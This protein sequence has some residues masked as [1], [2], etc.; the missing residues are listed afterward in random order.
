V[1]A[2]HS[3]VGVSVGHVLH[4]VEHVVSSSSPSLG[5][6]DDKHVFRLEKDPQ[7]DQYYFKSGLHAV[8]FK[9]N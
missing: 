5:Q 7:N 3:A 2:V 4:T 9:L 6:A 1:A 8:S